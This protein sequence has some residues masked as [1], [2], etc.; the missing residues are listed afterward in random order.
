MSNT[1]L[2]DI[3]QQVLG[4]QEVSQEERDWLRDKIS[5]LLDDVT[6]EHKKWKVSPSI[7]EEL[8]RLDQVAG[9]CR[10]LHRKLASLDEITR[11]QLDGDLRDLAKPRRLQ[12]PVPAPV[13]SAA[14]ARELLAQSWAGGVPP[15]EAMA[16][17]AKSARSYLARRAGSQSG[18]GV[19]RG[20]GNLHSHTHGDLRAHV[21]RELALMLGRYQG[22]G[23]VKATV[24]GKLYRLV[25]AA[26]EQVPGAGS[27]AAGS[28]M[29]AVVKRV[30][31]VARRMLEAERHDSDLGLTGFNATRHLVE[32]E[33]RRAV[34]QPKPRK[35]AARNQD[36]ISPENG[37]MP[38]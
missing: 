34:R 14:A 27:G 26:W 31:P 5:F 25:V 10:K 3:V 13:P 1:A 36:S 19:R 6:L 33:V 30:A 21:T 37:E 8:E 18:T 24:G 32:D 35:R 28:E 20:A 11:D 12:G 4:E 16:R 17:A 9:L 15:L 2:D 23:A 29:D 38:P 22:I 7:R